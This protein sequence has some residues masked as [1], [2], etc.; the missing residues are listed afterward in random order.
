MKKTG[1]QLMKAIADTSSLTT[2]SLTP[3]PSENSWRGQLR[4]MKTL[5]NKVA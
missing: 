5:E 3:N 1:C 4:R 2:R